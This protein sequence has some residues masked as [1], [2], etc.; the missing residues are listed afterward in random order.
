MP[1]NTPD[2]RGPDRR[3][4]QRRFYGHDRR[5]APRRLTCDCGGLINITLKDSGGREWVVFECARCRKKETRYLGAA[6]K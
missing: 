6:V 2:R 5:R 3:R 4:R 1:A